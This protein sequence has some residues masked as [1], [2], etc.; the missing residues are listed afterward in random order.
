[1]FR[2]Q[3]FG[4]FDG[5]N[6]VVVMVNSDNGSIMNEII[7]S[8]STVYK[9]KDFFKPTGRKAITVTGNMLDKYIGKYV[10]DKDTVTI[11]SDNGKTFLQVSNGENY[12]I[13][14]S[15][16]QDF[17]SPELPFDLK[18]EKDSSGKVTNIYFKND[19]GEHRA[20][21]LE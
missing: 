6:G 8:V 1:G 21:R 12:R 19:G 7:N 16:E 20:K 14:F 13:Y 5:G 10:L 11:N 2:S 9:W 18:F 4:S 15:S 17:F 3:Y